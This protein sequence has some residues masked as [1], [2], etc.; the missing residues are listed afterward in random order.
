M[1]PANEAAELLALAETAAQAAGRELARRY[2]DVRGLGT[3]STETDPVSDADRASEALLA[4]LLLTGRP[5]DGLV[6]E[7]GTSRPSRNG[8]TWVVDPLDGT[9]NYLYQWGSWSVSVAADDAEGT[10]VGVVHDPLAGLTFTGIRGKGAW[11]NGRPLRVNEPVPVS[12]ALLATGFAYLPARRARQADLVARLLRSVRDIRRSG[13][14]AL[15]LCFV[16][17]GKVDAYLEEHT[18]HWDRAAGA[19]IAREA[20]AVVT[21]AT[22]TGGE[23][24]ALAAG[25]TLHAELA[26]LI[27]LPAA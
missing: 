3:K 7:E 24:G 9:V 16:A 18:N 19:L 22:P 23:A 12:R 2:G 20:G 4:D 10:V 15:D 5:D 27:G 8:L 11:L 6:G 21:H 13:S 17:A 25:P 26:A 1:Q 14:A